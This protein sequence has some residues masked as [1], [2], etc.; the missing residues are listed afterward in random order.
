MGSKRCAH[1]GALLEQ[2]K[3]LLCEKSTLFVIFFLKDT[4]WVPRPRVNA[5]VLPENEAA[6]CERL[7]QVRLGHRMKLT[8]V[9]ALVGI[10][11]ERWSSYEYGRAPVPYAVAN[12]VCWQFGYSQRWLATGKPP[13]LHYVPIQAEIEAAIDKGSVFS[14]VFKDILA[15]PLSRFYADVSERLKVDEGAL[16]DEEEMLE[17]YAALEGG[18]PYRVVSMPYFMRAFKML[19]MLVPD[20]RLGEFFDAVNKA[21]NEFLGRH[22][23]EVA[24]HWKEFRKG[25]PMTVAPEFQEQRDSSSKPTWSKLIDTGGKIDKLI[26]VNP[27]DEN[28][29][30]WLKRLK[31]LC[32]VPG[33]Q[34]RLAED[35]RATKQHVSNWVKGASRPSA[36]YALRLREWIIQQESKTNR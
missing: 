28:W 18:A 21:A 10:S 22:K 26:Q 1:S 5:S 11:R 35:V 20:A 27:A 13:K 2:L 32:K 17:N 15:G 14:Q 36:D 29:G 12:A 19:V 33:T 25:D 24:A 3:Y 6:I 34:A 4:T 30:R 8:E 9:A 16:D 23:V 7:R 31:Q